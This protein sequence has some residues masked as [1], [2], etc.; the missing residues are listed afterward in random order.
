[1]SRSW[2]NLRAVLLAI[3]LGPTLLVPTAFAHEHEDHA[4][5][6]GSGDCHVC[7]VLAKM[8]GTDTP[9]AATVS[10]VQPSVPV[11]RAFIPP[12]RPLHRDLET[13]SQR[14]PPACS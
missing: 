6:E 14:G 13:H 9:A 11:R 12:V 1:M 8:A 10:F 4:D 2:P 5:H 7:I 3:L